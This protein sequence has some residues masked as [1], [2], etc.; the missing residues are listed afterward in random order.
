M[1]ATS[2]AHD[3]ILNETKF[4]GF[5]LFLEALLSLNSTQQQQVIVEEFSEDA[6]LVFTTCIEFTKTFSSAACSDNM[7]NQGR[8]T[9]VETN[10]HNHQARTAADAPP[11][12][13]EKNV[14]S[15]DSSSAIGTTLNVPNSSLSSSS[16]SKEKGKDTEKDKVKESSTST[17]VKTSRIN[18]NSHKKQ[19]A[20][21]CSKEFLTHLVA[22]ALSVA[23]LS[24][25]ALNKNNSNYSSEREKDKEKELE[26]QG[27]DF[28]GRK[29][30]ESKM[31]IR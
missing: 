20:Q 12:A 26:K 17:S 4:K 22:A 28:A 27:G 25:S 24:C 10:E 23:V 13:L 8:K 19:K 29:I 31:I 14:S 2:T 3:F 21:E 7:R 15:K 16:S 11:S 1:L 5:Q 30:V 6:L 18:Q 9:K